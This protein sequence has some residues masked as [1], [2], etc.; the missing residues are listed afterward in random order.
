MAHGD[1][2]I[3]KDSAVCHLSQWDVPACGNAV[4][5]E[6]QVDRTEE[7]P[8]GLKSSGVSSGVPGYRVVRVPRVLREEAGTRLRCQTSFSRC[9]LPEP[10]GAG[11]T[12]GAP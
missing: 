11:G 1:L 8:S 3:M 7:R 9:L 4:R 5:R 6:D 10:G 12:A 2:S